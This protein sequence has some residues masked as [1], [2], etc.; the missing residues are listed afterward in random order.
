MTKRSY[1]G[2]AALVAAINV[3][4]NRVVDA[5]EWLR[6]SIRSGEL[7]PGQ[8]MAE[9]DLAK[10]MGLSRTPVR[11]ALSRLD[12]DGL[13]LSKGR[14]VQL[15]VLTP[16]EI[17]EVMQCRAALEGY[18]AGQVARLQ[19]AGLLRPADL[20]RIEQ[21][22]VEC[23]Q[24]TRTRGAADG[25]LAN[26]AFHLALAALAGNSRL[27]AELGR[28]WDQL[29]VATRAGL[30]L[31]ERL[32]TVHAEHVA[33]MTAVVA[34]QPDPARAAVER[35]VDTTTTLATDEVAEP[36]LSAH[37]IRGVGA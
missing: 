15:R 21:L 20:A 6:G 35:H 11:E 10:A 2:E 23:D 18:A 16:A 33:I 14:G 4:N 9:A 7:L 24:I 1:G 22:L 17:V 31:P 5:Y 34:G 32:D 12:G 19:S 25:A 26:R 29:L 37:G 30:D 36:A 28:L 13:V 8:R 27:D 3:C